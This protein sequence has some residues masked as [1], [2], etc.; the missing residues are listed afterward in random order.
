MCF[1]LHFFYKMHVTHP[2]K[3]YVFQYVLYSITSLK[4]NLNDFSHLDITFDR[5]VKLFF[6]VLCQRNINATRS[7]FNH[8]YPITNLDII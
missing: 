8:E 7:I 6:E 3:S 5:N 4:L 2:R 1:V